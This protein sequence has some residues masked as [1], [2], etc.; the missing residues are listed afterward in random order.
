MFDFL[1]KSKNM[2]LVR[3]GSCT[4]S[5][6][7]FAKL[8]KIFRSASAAKYLFSDNDAAANYQTYLGLMTFPKD[9]SSIYTLDP[10][11]RNSTIFSDKLLMTMMFDHYQGIQLLEI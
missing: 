5:S 9:Y 4:K 3:R 10:C 1:A 2:H 8:L 11:M 7:L 6:A